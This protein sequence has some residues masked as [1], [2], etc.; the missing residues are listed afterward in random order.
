[1]ERIIMLGNQ[2]P[3]TTLIGEVAGTYS[4]EMGG[5]EVIF[6]FWFN[7][8]G[9]VHGSFEAEGESLEIRGVASSRSGTI[10]GF[11]LDAAGE[12]PVAMFRARPSVAGLSLQVDVPDFDELMDLCNPETVTLNKTLDF[13]SDFSHAAD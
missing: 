3:E 10:V 1:M 11:F 12:T 6:R 8:A 2:L 9:Y 4:A 7:Q 13:Q 5:T